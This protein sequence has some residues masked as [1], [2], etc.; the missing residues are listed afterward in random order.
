MK[1]K[2]LKKITRWLYDISHDYTIADRDHKEETDELMIAE[3]KEKVSDLEEK[4][5]AGLVEC[6]IVNSVRR[7]IK[8]QFCEKVDM[9]F[10]GHDDFMPSVEAEICRKIGRYLKEHHLV[11]IKYNDDFHYGYREVYGTIDV[12]KK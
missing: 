5:D 9:R 3:L 10:I 1:V 12:L 4:L 11:E 8:I 6:R 2:F 7:P